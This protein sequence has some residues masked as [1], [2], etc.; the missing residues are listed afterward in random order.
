MVVMVSSMTLA[1]DY[2]QGSTTGFTFTV[3]DHRSFQTVY[4]D[5][6]GRSRLAAS[7]YNSIILKD[8]GNIWGW[9][10]KIGD[11]TAYYRSVPSLVSG[12]NGVKSV[13]ANG[14]NAALLNDGTVWTWG[15]N[16]YGQLGDGTTAD[17]L[18]PVRVLQL[19][20]VAAIA[21]G[22]HHCLAL[23]SDG[24]VC[25]WG[26]NFYG[27]LGD[28][29]R[30]DR[31]IPVQ[32]TGMNGVTAIAAGLLRSVAVRS[33]GTVWRWG[34]NSPIYGDEPMENW[35]STVPVQV[36][37]LTDI[38]NVVAGA[39]FDVA[40]KRDGTIWTWGDNSY[41]QLG[42]GTTNGTR[43]PVQVVGLSNVVAIAA[44][45]VFA[46]A[47]LSDGT[48]WQWG[49]GYGE[50]LPDGSVP[51]HKT[52]IQVPGINGVVQIAAG[53]YHTV[54]LKSDGSIWVWGSNSDSQLG[55]AVR[56]NMG[57]AVPVQIG[58]LN[59]TPPEGNIAVNDGAT[60]T[61]S[62]QVTL[63]ISATWDSGTSLMMRFCEDWSYA[64][65]DW[66]P[67]ATTKIWALQN[68]KFQN[69][70]VAQFCDSLGNISACK[71]VTIYAG[72][73]VTVGKAKASSYASGVLL[74]G[75][76]VTGKFADCTYIEDV[77]RTAGIAVRPALE[78]KPGDILDLAGRRSSGGSREAYIN[79]LAHK[80]TGTG[81]V[82]PIGLNNIS[83]GGGDWKPS[84]AAHPAQVGIT[85]A[86]GLNNIGMLVTTWGKVVNYQ[87][88]QG[89]TVGL[90]TIDDGSVYG[91]ISCELPPDAVFD[92]SWTYVTVTGISS[93]RSIPYPWQ[94]SRLVRVREQSDIVAIR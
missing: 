18:A 38:T 94:V 1:G 87:P 12:I 27:G 29:T 30:T 80:V 2:S 74:S 86:S 23:K 64:W 82:R 76:V 25:A 11:G 52:P 71:D 3:K 45:Q 4:Q 21:E 49:L 35:L 91:G 67:Y 46:V 19:E 14:S 72:S 40:L 85:G 66:E 65:S 41:G 84:G 36:T 34:E 9:G 51:V 56:S 20:G 50:W 58:S 24:T 13:V 88:Q 47:L 54:A 77:N 8:D 22:G 53:W 92:P 42:D 39:Y 73:P 63:D 32:V 5:D 93:C 33:D 48:V 55:D 31:H 78:C 69:S 81:S 89:Q 6:Q 7:C 57:S 43:I 37:G 59:G 79:V 16:T 62:T 26:Y 60:L 83:V 28:G 10:S 75:A 61:F 44:G 70:I 15:T 17:R 68:D 90:I